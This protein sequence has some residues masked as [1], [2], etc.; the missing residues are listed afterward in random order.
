M[1]DSRESQ[2]LKIHLSNSATQEARGVG[3]SCQLGKIWRMIWICNNSPVAT[4]IVKL[5]V[6]H[7][8]LLTFFWFRVPHCAEC[9]LCLLHC[10]Q[11]WFSVTLMLLMSTGQLFCS[12]SLLV[13]LLVFPWVYWGCLILVRIP[14]QWC[15]VLLIVSHPMHMVLCVCWVSLL[16]K[17]NSPLKLRTV[18]I[19]FFF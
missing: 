13:L 18:L 10:L 8:P 1:Q 14:Q 15:C 5:C 16:V 11:S 2:H 9:V 7:F 17:L 3:S 12:L 6:I 4:G 19:A